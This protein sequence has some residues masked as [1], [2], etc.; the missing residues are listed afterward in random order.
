MP[1]VLCAK[2]IINAGIN[3]IVFEGEYP[4]ELYMELLKEAEIEMTK[5]GE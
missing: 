1:C 4:D 2:M 3:R 5:F